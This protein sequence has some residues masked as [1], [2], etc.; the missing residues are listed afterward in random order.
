MLGD[1][2]LRH[3][4]KRLAVG[5]SGASGAALGLA[6]LDLLREAGGWESHLVVT[7]GGEL[8]IAHELGMTLAEF[9][10]HADVTHEVG[11]LS[12]S[13]AS[14]TF[15]CEGM[16]VAPCSMK[17]VAGIAGGY[18]E[19]LLLRAADVT[20]KEQRRLVLLVRESPLSAIHLDNLA[21]LARVPGA[22]I[23]PPMLTFYN[24]PQSVGDMVRHIACKALGAFGVKCSGYVRWEG[25]AL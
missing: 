10:S 22:M 25:Q 15:A 16:V 1:V 24:D 2:Y 20:L 4:K 14:G 17:T 19:N 11:E 9:S 18:S 13:I 3:D 7:H 5:V 23:M 21:R 8:T 12:A 6:C